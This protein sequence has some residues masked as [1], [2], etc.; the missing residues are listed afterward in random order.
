LVFF[1]SLLLSSVFHL[2]ARGSVCLLVLFGS[3][4]HLLAFADLVAGLSV[5]LCPARSLELSRALAFAGGL[6]GQ[7]YVGG[8]EA[9]A[10]ANWC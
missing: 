3:F 6:G 8:N 10:S 1:S 4:R 7:L 9:G 5:T 2:D